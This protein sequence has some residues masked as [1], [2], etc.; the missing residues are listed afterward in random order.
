M[1]DSG[2][3]QNSDMAA[4]IKSAYEEFGPRFSS[5]SKEEQQNIV[6][7]LVAAWIGLV[8]STSSLPTLPEQAQAGLSG[9][10]GRNQHERARGGSEAGQKA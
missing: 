3:S 2:L 5:A 7:P 6:S 9:T 4:S 10:S 8:R 1:R